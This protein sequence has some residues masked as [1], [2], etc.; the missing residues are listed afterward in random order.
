MVHLKTTTSI[1]N[2]IMYSLLTFFIMPT[3]T[4]PHLKS[5]KD[6]CPIGFLLGF[7]ISVILWKILP[8]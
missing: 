7:I 6:P 5:M 8:R 4:S 1:V 3:I 2:L